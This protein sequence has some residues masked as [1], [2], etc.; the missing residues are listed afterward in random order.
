[1]ADLSLFN[2]LSNSTRLQREILALESS[3]DESKKIELL[4]P[5]I[6]TTG[7]TLNIEGGIAKI[8][9]RIDV[10]VPEK[11][12]GSEEEEVVD[13]EVAAASGDEKAVESVGEK[14]V[15]EG[16]SNE[17][18]AVAKDEKEGG[19]I[20]Q[21]NES[22]GDEKDTDNDGTE[23]KEATTTEEVTQ[24]E[25]EEEKADPHVVLVLDASLYWRPDSS[26]SSQST[27]PQ[28]YP[29]QKPLAIL[30]YGSNLFSG[31]STIQNGDEVDI[32]LDWTPSIHLSDAVTNVALKIRECVKRGEPL[33]AT[34]REDNDDDGFSGSLLR[35]AREA[36]ESLL[37]TKKAVG[38]IFSSGLSSLSAKGSSFAA[39]GESA[40]KRM[41]KSILNLGESLS[42]IAAPTMQGEKGATEETEAAAGGEEGSEKEESSKKVVKAI[43]D[44]GDEIDLSDD[45]WNKCIGMYSCKAIK[46]PEFI[47][48][49]LSNS[50]TNQKEVSEVDGWGAC[51]I[52]HSANQLMEILNIL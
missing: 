6:K 31:G 24:Q 36:K 22:T 5:F 33:H 1:M 47:E 48:A 14:N 21:K 13:S 52:V 8:E 17:E 16:D 40:S 32:D 11:A 44:I 27:S 3:D 12:A 20:A 43:P 4:P 45:P 25:K 7:H 19:D 34:V 2:I 46:R 51:L 26:S 10:E 49:L 28:C 42:T 50:A 18:N 39:K 15:E 9:F 23:S 35:E 38:A 29:F 41:S 37:E 30:K